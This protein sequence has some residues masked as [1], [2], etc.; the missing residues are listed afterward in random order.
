MVKPFVREMSRKMSP[1]IEFP[2]STGKGEW[3]GGGGFIHACPLLPHASGWIRAG[4]AAV[5]C[6]A[7]QPHPGPMSVHG[8]RPWWAGRTPSAC[9]QAGAGATRHA[10]AAQ[11]PTPSTHDWA[12]R[13]RPGG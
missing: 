7:A 13:R 12:R 11:A 10:L 5:A 6:T 8:G 4:A 2:T 1:M 3:V 9:C